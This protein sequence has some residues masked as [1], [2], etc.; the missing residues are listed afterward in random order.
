M[1]ILYLERPDVTLCM[2][3]QRKL[4]KKD[5]S[6]G[7]FYASFQESSDAEGKKRVPTVF[8]PVVSFIYDLRENTYY[9]RIQRRQ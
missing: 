3:N 1:K 4:Q 7:N 8:N 6:N 9:R 2:G 5:N